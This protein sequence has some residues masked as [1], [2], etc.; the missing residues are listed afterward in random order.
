MQF[1]SVYSTKCFSDKLL[2]CS[3]GER[4]VRLEFIDSPKMRDLELDSRVNLGESKL[5]IRQNSCNLPIFMQT[6]KWL[7]SYF[8]GEM[9]RFIPRI[10]F[11]RNASSF[12][13]RV[14]EILQTIPYGKTTTYGAIAT[15]IAREF[16]TAKMSAQAVGGALSRNP[17]AIIIPCHR[18]VGANGNLVGYTGGIA[19][20][21]ALLKIEKSPQK[22]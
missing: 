6:K 13:L 19:N 22:P 18:V 17:I 7:D 14:W 10:V 20:K 12:S 11:P 8:S 15:Q 9:P 1:M 2:L 16:G 3:D 4:L 21:I 5:D